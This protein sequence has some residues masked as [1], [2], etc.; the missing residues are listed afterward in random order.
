MVDVAASKQ[1]NDTVCSLSQSPAAVDVGPHTHQHHLRRRRRRRVN[2]EQQRGRWWRGRVVMTPRLLPHP[3]R[4]VVINS[5]V[6]ESRG[7]LLFLLL[8][9][10]RIPLSSFSFTFSSSSSIPFSSFPSSSFFSCAPSNPCTT[11]S[12]FSSATFLPF[13]AFKSVYYPLCLTMKEIFQSKTLS[14]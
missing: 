13:V 8:L 2:A 12:F 6:V 14:A 11:L 4:D 1:N 9:L 3:R 5:R 7:S 10:L